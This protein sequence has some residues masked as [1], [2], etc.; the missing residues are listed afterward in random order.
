MDLKEID[1][2]SQSCEWKKSLSLTSEGLEALCG[3]LNANQGHGKVIFGVTDDGKEIGVE[4]GNLDTAQR[5]LAQTIQQKFEPRIRPEIQVKEKAGKKF[6]VLSCAR[7]PQIPYHE[8]DG[9]AF[10]RIG[11]TTRKLNPQEKEQLTRERTRVAFQRFVVTLVGIF[12]VIV[13]MI[14]FRTLQP[15]ATPQ[16]QPPGKPD[17]ELAFFVENELRFNY[18]NNT[19][20]AAHNPKYW[21]AVENYTHPVY[22]DGKIATL[23]IITTVVNDFV[24]PHS[25]QGNVEVIDSKS[26]KYAAK[27]DRLFGLGA[28]TCEDCTGTRNYWMY[29]KLG[30]GGWYSPIKAGSSGMP[31]FDRKPQSDEAITTA[32][33]R[34][35]PQQDRIQ[36]PDHN[37]LTI[38]ITP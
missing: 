23:P 21:F 11:T 27:G 31:F 38:S 5:S 6:V 3:M 34:L 26:K 29:Y 30:E 16:M 10:I 18:I 33:E 36:M 8:F 19:A 12:V 37:P 28:I 22:R 32:L 1:P 15:K 9:R 25:F 20:N 13:L 24:R 2:E 4:P 7:D 14:A 35:V 17:L